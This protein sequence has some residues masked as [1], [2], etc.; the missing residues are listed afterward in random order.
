MK[1]FLAFIFVFASLNSFAAQDSCWQLVVKQKGFNPG[2]YHYLFTDYNKEGF[3]I[4]RGMLYDIELM[5]GKRYLSRL[6]DIFPD[7]LI[8]STAFN[9]VIAADR[10]IEYEIFA[11]PVDSIRYLRIIHEIPHLFLM[12]HDISKHEFIYTKSDTGCNKIRD[13]YHAVEYDPNPPVDAFDSL[14]KNQYFTYHLSPNSFFSNYYSHNNSGRGNQFPLGGEPDTSLSIHN[15]IGLPQKGALKVNGLSLG[16]ETKNNL[17][18]YFYEPAPLQINGIN[19]EVNPIGL[20]T[21]IPPFFPVLWAFELEFQDSIEVYENHIRQYMTTQINGINL[22]PIIFLCN[23][24]INGIN[25]VGVKTVIGKSNGIMVSGLINASYKA[26]G[27]QFAGIRNT[28]TGINGIQIAAISNHTNRINGLQISLFNYASE[29]TG[30]QI[31]LW[32]K[33]GDRGLPFVNLSF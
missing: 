14:F 7:T 24:K 10:G 27:L 18:N 31:G 23:A 32:N 29:M 17:Y 12:K 20:V 4:E 33:I 5:N 28:A 22:S 19:L 9:V 1:K 15:F 21:V 6:I 30:L 2:S 11:C 3:I 13:D 25:I 16:L 8:I 26:N